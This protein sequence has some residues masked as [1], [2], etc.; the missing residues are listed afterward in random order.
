MSALA[1]G[2]SSLA[3]RVAALDLLREADLVV[4]GE[5]RV[6]PDVGEVEPDEIFLVPLD[7]LLRHPVTPWLVDARPGDLVRAGPRTR[8]RACS[9]RML[10]L[11]PVHDTGRVKRT[12]GERSERSERG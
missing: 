9:P 5:Q 6:L 8:V 3:R 1:A 4:L 2:S 11:L 10:L 12:Q 7:T